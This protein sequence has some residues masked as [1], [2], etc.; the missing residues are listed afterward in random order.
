MDIPEHKKLGSPRDLAAI[1]AKYLLAERY[2]FK[3]S[4]IDDYK[5]NITLELKI[6][7]DI[8]RGNLNHS[9]IDFTVFKNILPGFNPYDFD[10]FPTLSMEA[11]GSFYIQRSYNLL[12]PEA[13]AM[14]DGEQGEFLK[15]YFLWQLSECI[16][17]NLDSSTK[18]AMCRKFKDP[19]EKSRIKK[20]VNRLKNIKYYF[21][22]KKNNRYLS[23]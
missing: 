16:C 15:K 14:P 17:E 10:A 5:K 9:N 1:L 18:N 19:R 2:I 23:K 6:D 12:F 3:D 21:S 8:K 7:T 11:T 22:K 13:E 20:I 4:R